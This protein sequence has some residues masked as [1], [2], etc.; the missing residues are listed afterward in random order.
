MP[1]ML[2]ASWLCSFR[3]TSRPLHSKRPALPRLHVELLED[4]CTPAAALSA[5]LVADIVPGAASSSP[6]VLQNVNGTLYF[7][8]VDPASSTAGVYRSDGTDA[9]TVCLTGGI[10]SL[11]TFDFTPLNGS[12][13]FFTSGGP[14]NAAG[15]WKTDGTP[16]GTTLLRSVWV[17]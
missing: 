8:A 14:G 13:L 1:I 6:F 12:V 10:G 2:L 9:G 11:P 3:P 7:G 16:G 15:L 17:P 5:S 4:R